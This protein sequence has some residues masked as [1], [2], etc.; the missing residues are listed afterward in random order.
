MLVAAL[1]VFA[2]TSLANDGAY[3]VD[4][5]A[6][7]ASTQS[8]EQLSQEADRAREQD[9]ADQAIQLYQRALA[10]RP[11]WE[12]GLW[13]AGTLLYDKNQYASAL[14]MFRRFVAVRPDAGAGWALLGMSEFQLRDYERSL[15]HLRRAMALGMGDRE[16]LKRSVFYSVTTLLTRF[17]QYDDSLGLLAG[18]VNNGKCDTSVMEAA[19]LAGLRL[20]LLPAEIPRE[21][22]QMIRMAGQALCAAQ[23]G[24]HD[25]ALKLFIALRDAYPQEPGVHFLVGS[26]LM[27]IR[28]D[29]GIQEMKREIEISPSHVP[30]RNR[31][32]EQYIKMERFDDALALA[33]EA[34]KLAPKSYSVGITMGEALIGKGDLAGG[35]HELEVAQEMVPDNLRIRWDL[36]RAYTAAGRGEDAK[37]EKQE[38]ENLNQQGAKPQ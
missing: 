37:R 35:I 11:E 34:R 14:D 2:L 17:E 12:E 31:L 33:Q 1:F 18:I 36:V 4:R 3:A 20:P 25:E 22:E 27:N 29:D 32:A 15:D 23:V 28:P 24:Q 30:A 21:R 8:F 26:F 6:P 5:Q 13:Y 10:L 19:G 9:R 7:A 16:D 38:I